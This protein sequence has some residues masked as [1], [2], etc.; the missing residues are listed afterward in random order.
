MYCA[1][2]LSLV[3]QVRQAFPRNAPT[4][5]HRR[6]YRHDRVDNGWMHAAKARTPVLTNGKALTAALSFQPA[7][8]VL[9]TRTLPD[10]NVLALPPD[11]PPPAEESLALFRA[12]DVMMRLD[13]GRRFAQ[14][15]LSSGAPPGLWSRRGA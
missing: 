11:P 2:R 5:T 7:I 4:S 12:W 6:R 9:P 1:R 3:F 14:P 15:G 13:P 8:L 10:Q